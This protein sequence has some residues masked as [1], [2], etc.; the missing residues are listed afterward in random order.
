MGVIVRDL[1]PVD[2]RARKDEE[3]CQRNRHA[4]C[5][6]AIGE[7]NRPRP[8]VSR[9]LVIGEQRLMATKRLAFGVVGDAAP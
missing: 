9:D 2:L 1:E 4:R 3:I 5:P 7:L 8:D 6:G